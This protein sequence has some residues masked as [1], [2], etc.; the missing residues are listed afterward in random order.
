MNTIRAGVTVAVCLLVLGTAGPARSQE[1]DPAELAADLARQA[2][3]SYEVGNIDGAIEL[4]HQAIEVIPDPAFAFNLAQLYD[5]IDQ[6]PQARDWYETYLG[7]YEYGPDNRNYVEERIEELVEI[8]P[9]ECAHVVVTTDPPGAEVVIHTGGRD[10]V[11]GVT[12]LDAYVAPGSITVN[13]SLDG[14]QLVTRNLNAVAGVRLELELGALSVVEGPEE[15]SNLGTIPAFSLIGVG[16]LGVL[17]GIV[18]WSDGKDSEDE[19]N[20]LVSLIGTD[21]GR[22]VTQAELDQLA[23]AAEDSVSSGNLLFGLGV[24]A[25]VGGIA[26]LVLSSDTGSAP[27]D[28][29]VS[30]VPLVGGVCVSWSGR[31]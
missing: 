17:L 22:G 31:F 1:E 8:I 10:Q 7:F 6:F 15:E 25:I 14:Y 26:I 2:A 13:A 29:Q 16:T 27:P 18:S 30:V 11:Y 21:A 12:P 24:T 5:S 9:R 23:A 28:T 3:D 19:H 4:F 20:R